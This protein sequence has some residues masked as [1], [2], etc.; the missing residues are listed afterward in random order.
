[1]GVKDLTKLIKK[2]APD[3]ISKKQYSDFAGEIWAIDA[4]IFFY[5]FCHDPKNKKPNPHIAGFYQLIFRLI[6]HQ[7]TPVIVFDGAV[8]PEKSHTVSKRKEREIK[9]IDEIKSIQSEVLDMVCH[10]TP[11][12]EFN[13][14][15]ML[16]TSSTELNTEVKKKLEKLEQVQ[17][18]IIT[19]Q[20]NT[21]TDVLHLCELMGVK[22]Y[23]AK[24]EADALC[25]KLSR[26]GIVDAVMSE[27]ADI[28]LYRGNR[29]IRKFNWTNTV[30]LVDLNKVLSGFELSYEQFID[31]CILAGTDY[32]ND[33][34]SGMGGIRA[35]ELIKRGLKIE[36]IL[37]RINQAHFDENGQTRTKTS[38]SKDLKTYFK[39]SPP[40]D[41]NYQSAR[42]LIHKAHGLENDCEVTKFDLNQFMGNYSQIKTILTSKCKYR[43]DTVDKH[44]S[45][46]QKLKPIVQT[47]KIQ[48]NIH[49]KKKLKL[50]LKLN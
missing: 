17:K 31:L 9:Y 36:D 13:L 14:Q 40:N 41:F 47:T 7:I 42:D 30:E 34:I 45:Q 4:S 2:Y 33:T 11:Y 49:L 44:L 19:F 21:Y 20:T 38:L 3:A 16:A 22:T 48:Q 46:L 28:L 6:S 50:K 35:Y 43:S 5:R 1:M 24:W 29:L 39:Y 15:N 37:D 10:D 18:K 25:T 27:D 8:P 26:Q 23:R 12:E 32:T